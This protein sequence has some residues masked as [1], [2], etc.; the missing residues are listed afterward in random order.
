MIERKRYTVPRRVIAAAVR[1]RHDRACQRSG[2]CG[3]GELCPVSDADGDNI[4]FLGGTEPAPCPYR[5]AFGGK[6]VCTC[7]VHYDLFARYRV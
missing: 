1:C 6:Q 2:R 3:P 4:L 5:L 7:P